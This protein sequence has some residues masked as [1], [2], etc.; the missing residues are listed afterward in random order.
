MNVRALRAA[1]AVLVLAVGTWAGLRIH[2]S[3]APPSVALDPAGRSPAGAANPS[4]GSDFDV[5]DGPPGPLPKIPDRLPI[6]SL[7]DRAGKPTSIATWRDKSLIINFW[8]SWCAPCRHEIPLLESL[9][10]EWG[11]RGVEVVGIAVDHRDQAL[12]YA[13]QLKIAYPLLIGE[14]DALDVAGQLGFESPVFP[15]TVFT[16]R[17]GEVVT[18]YVGELHQAQADLILSTVQDLN[19]NHVQL[20]QARRSIADGLHALAPQHPG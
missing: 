18:L 20:P 2:A 16:D 4:M 19:Q 15:F 7:A 3:L 12:A 5:A 17:R 9:S 8:A 14:E 13:D 1:G 6:F 10:R 11:S